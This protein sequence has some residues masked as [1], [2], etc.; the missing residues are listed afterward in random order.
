[1]YEH[2]EFIE[3]FSRFE[4]LYRIKEGYYIRIEIYTSYVLQRGK[5]LY[6]RVSFLRRII[7][8]ARLYIHFLDH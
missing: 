7:I 5:H 8:L 2:I 6:V 4:F 3:S 1:M